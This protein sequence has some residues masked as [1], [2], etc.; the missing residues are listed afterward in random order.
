MVNYIVNL[1]KGNCHKSHRLDKNSNTPKKS[2]L[3]QT[4]TGLESLNFLIQSRTRR[5]ALAF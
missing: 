2:L 4:P 5:D 1:E 3:D